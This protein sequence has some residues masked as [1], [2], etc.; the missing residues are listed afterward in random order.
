MFS[1][2]LAWRAHFLGKEP[3]ALKDWLKDGFCMLYLGDV[4]KKN[5]TSR[6]RSRRNP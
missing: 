3:L 5:R 6:I 2:T 1:W 4:Q